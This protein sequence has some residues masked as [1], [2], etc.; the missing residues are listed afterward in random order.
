MLHDKPS[1]YT[2]DISGNYETVILWVGTQA[3]SPKT[4]SDA[5]ASHPYFGDFAYFQPLGLSFRNYL[6]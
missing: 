3:E 6:Y 1:L 5:V 4:G 2:I